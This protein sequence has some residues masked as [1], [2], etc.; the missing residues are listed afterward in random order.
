MDPIPNQPD[1]DRWYKK[2][3]AMN[4]VADLAN[5]DRYLS[6]LMDNA[7][8]QRCHWESGDANIALYR[9]NKH[10]ELTKLLTSDRVLVMNDFAVEITRVSSGL[11]LAAEFTVNS[12]LFSVR[13]LNEKLA[14]YDEGS[15][16]SIGISTE[17]FTELMLSVAARYVSSGGG[18]PRMMMEEYD[19]SE[20][21]LERLS[22][23]V[24]G[25]G[26]VQG[27]SSRTTWAVVED[28]TNSFV[29]RL[30]EIET[31]NLSEMNHLIQAMRENELFALEEGLDITQTNNPS[32]KR[33]FASSREISCT[34]LSP[35]PA[36]FTTHALRRSFIDEG[37]DGF[38]FRSASG[39]GH[40]DSRGYA[41]D[42][43]HFLELLYKLM[44]SL[45]QP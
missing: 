38:R 16:T 39:A 25:L 10:S 13:G 2:A 27:E 15:G 37:R 33:N 18:S 22:A 41:D 29:A 4:R 35:D 19:R 5:D 40:E 43:I 44:P 24:Y 3:D 1:Y 17:D 36:R 12:R 23:I 8:R 7:L 20:N 34:G 45:E 11:G 14:L 26:G 42:C 9:D 28:D 21:D 31:P 30:T 6:F 32:E